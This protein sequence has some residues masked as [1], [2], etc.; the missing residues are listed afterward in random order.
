MS[1][2]LDSI[3]FIGGGVMAEAMTQGLLSKKLVT[4]KSITVGEPREERRRELQQKYGI[5]VT[6]ANREA[7][8]SC[9][10]LVLSVKPQDLDGVLADLKGALRP[11]QMVMSI[12]AGARIGTISR[13]LSH[14]AIVRVMPNTPAQ[15][16]EGMSVWT[17]T[18]S[19]RKEQLSQATTILQALGKEIYVNDEKFLDM[20]TAVSGTG[21]TYVFLVMEAMVDAA[22]HLGFPRHIAYQLVTETM[23]GSVS[24]A[25]KSGKHPAELRNMVTSPGGTSAAALYQLEK[26]SIRTV[27]SKAIFAAYERSKS[28]GEGTSPT[29]DKNDNS[30]K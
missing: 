15:I 29:V 10:T 25:I 9:K 19:V 30:Q 1:T 8:H 24:Y 28:L 14:S 13:G 23:R 26:G 4:R 27:L 11:E 18:P 21:P 5:N 2:V 17:A 12:V 20:A 7:A 16:G 6:A 22:V 3:S